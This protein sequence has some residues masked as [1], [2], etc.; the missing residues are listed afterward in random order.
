[1]ESKSKKSKKQVLEKK[2]KKIKKG[3]KKGLKYDPSKN[4]PTLTRKIVKN[5]GKA[6][7]AFAASN[8]AKRFSFSIR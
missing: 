4:V 7:A 1:M 3:T 8:N 2:S 5:F 6:I